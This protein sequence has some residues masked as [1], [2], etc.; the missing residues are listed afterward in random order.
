MSKVRQELTAD[1]KIQID[2]DKLNYVGGG[3]ANIDIKN[4]SEFAEFLK[5]VNDRHNFAKDR[6]Q[7]IEKHILG[8]IKQID[9]ELD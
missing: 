4:S 6:F 3:L 8:L 5:A 9:K 7:S 1:W 2:G